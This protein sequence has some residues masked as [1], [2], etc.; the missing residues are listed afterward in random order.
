MNR[1]KSITKKKPSFYL[2]D[3]LFNRDNVSRLAQEIHS[4]HMTFNTEGFIRDVL[5]DFPKYEL[6]QRMHHI[7]DMLFVYL[8]KDYTQAIDIIVRALPRELDPKKTDG[9][10]G[11]FIYGSYAE[12]VALHGLDTQHLKLSLRT[13]EEITKRFSAE[14]A[15]RHFLNKHTRETLNQCV[16][17]SK[18]DNYHVRRLASEGSRPRLPWGIK[19]PLHYSQTEKILDTLFSDTARYVTRSVAN[20]LNDISKIDPD[21]VIKKLHEW[22]SSGKQHSKEINFIKKHSLRTL[23]KKN[24]FKD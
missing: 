2:K 13:L 9:D 20:H 7:R 19:V 23:R 6:K 18:S 16:V 3:R 11:D 12:Y 14:Y 15:I 24:M 22:E 5:K 1:K 21:Y 8:P 4:V 10:Y 17:W